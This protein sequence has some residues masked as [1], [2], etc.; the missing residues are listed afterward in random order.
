MKVSTI[1]AAVVAVVVLASGMA[2]AATVGWKGV[3]WT[4]YGSNTTAS[5]NANDGLDITVLGGQSGDPGNDNWVLNGFLP[6]N[7]TQA[8]AP[9]VKFTIT[10]TYTGDP[11]VG[12]P[13]SFLDV[14]N[15]NGS[16]ETMWQGGVYA[17]HSPYYLNHNI[18]DANNGGWDN[19]PSN[20]YIGPTR[21]AG[22]HTILIG[23]RTDGQ[24]DMWF[25]GVLGQ[26]IAASPNCTSFSQTWLGVSTDPGTTFTATYADLQWGTGYVA[27]IPEPAT[28]SLVA[29]AIGGLAL[30][31]KRK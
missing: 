6:G 21:S 1:N 23:M 27:P 22:D 4:E 9:W 8:N 11:T 14:Y 20:W 13:R 15:G 12:G 17:D 16:V 3:T 7:L 10:D 29:L 2:S 28:L 5:V 18:Y 19:D 30:I 26:T 24:V 31:R 25:D